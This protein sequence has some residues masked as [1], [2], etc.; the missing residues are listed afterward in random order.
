LKRVG[1]QFERENES[2]KFRPWTQSIPPV[3]ASAALQ[4]SPAGILLLS[5]SIGRFLKSVFFRV[6]PQIHLWA[7]ARSRIVDPRF[8]WGS[9]E[10]HPG[11]VACPSKKS[12]I[13]ISV[14]GLNDKAFEGA[15]E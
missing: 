3:C 5:K 9:D 2:D 13:A 15:G 10:W 7:L 11:Y 14:E 4:Y 1:G 8:L 12:T 6:R